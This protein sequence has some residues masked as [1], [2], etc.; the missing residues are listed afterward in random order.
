MIA[1]RLQCAAFGGL[2]PET[3]KLLRQKSIPAPPLP[4]VG[5]RLTR[6]YRGKFYEAEVRRDGVAYAGRT[7][8]SLS[9]VART[10]TGTHWNGPRFSAACEKM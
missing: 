3:L 7:Y 4:P 6:E 1:W 5:T 10:I 2:E 9:E 8:G